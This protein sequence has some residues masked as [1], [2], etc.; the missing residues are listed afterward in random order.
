MTVNLPF[1]SIIVAAYNAEES[2][3]RCLEHLLNLDYPDYE[4]IVVDNNSTDKTPGLIKKYN[5]IYLIEEK[6]GWPAARSR[7]IKYSKA[8]FV[9]NI[10]F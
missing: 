5:V 8:D 3:E 7:G 9:A 4:I 10:D 2:I 6:R 1:V